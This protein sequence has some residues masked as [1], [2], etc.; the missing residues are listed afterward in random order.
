[1]RTI[2]PRFTDLARAIAKGTT[3]AENDSVATLISQTSSILEVPNVI[4]DFSQPPSGAIVEDSFCWVNAGTQA[5]AFAGAVTNWM[6]FA[7]GMWRLQGTLERGFAGTANTANSLR[8]NLGQLPVNATTFA[9]CNLMNVVEHSQVS[10]NYVFSLAFD[11]QLSF[12]I[13]AQLAG[14]TLGYEFHL[15]ASRIF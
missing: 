7:R 5:G 12:S 10:F 4:R 3:Q 13:G 11:A 15:L 9:L 2:T 1:M 8:V 14:D 6:Q